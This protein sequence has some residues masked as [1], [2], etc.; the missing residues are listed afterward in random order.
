MTA[1]RSCMTLRSIRALPLIPKEYSANT[2][3]AYHLVAVLMPPNVLVRDLMGPVG[4]TCQALPVYLGRATGPRGI[5]LLVDLRGRLSRISTE[6][7]LHLIYLG[8]HHIRFGTQR[9]RSLKMRV[10][11]DT[12][13]EALCPLR[14][15]LRHHH[16]FDFESKYAEF[17][18]WC[19]SF[20]INVGCL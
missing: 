17:V 8:I 19:C 13:F 5:N 20:Y 12:S 1:L 4:S 16:R 15:K 10:I 2:P 11:G 3:M 9:E 6:F 14:N 7:Y 18:V